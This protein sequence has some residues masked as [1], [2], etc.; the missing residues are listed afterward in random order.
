MKRYLQKADLAEV[1]VLF[2]VFLSVSLPTAFPA[3]KL[4]MLALIILAILIRGRV[5]MHSYLYAA[6]LFAGVF[7]L[8]WTIYGVEAGN[9][10]A[11]RVLTVMMVYPIVLPIIFSVIGEHSRERLVSVFLWSAIVIICFDFLVVGAS[12]FSPLQFFSDVSRTIYAEANTSDAQEYFK[13]SV[14]NIASVIFLLPFFLGAYFFGYRPIRASLLIALILSLLAIAI[15]S[16]RRA[17]LLTMFL[18]PIVAVLITRGTRDAGQSGRAGVSKL[19]SWS[20]MLISAAAVTY[21]FVDV[22]GA[23]YFANQLSSVADFAENQSNIERRLQF[24]ALY[25]GIKDSPFF[26]Q[27]AGAAASY[28]RSQEMPW[29]YELY[30]MSIAFQYGLLGFLLYSALIGV[31]L[32]WLINRVRINGRASFEF[33]YLAG[34]LAFLFASFTNPYLGKFD[35][36][37]MIFVLY[38]L[39]NDRMLKAGGVSARHAY[40]V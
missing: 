9:P 33:S 14:P 10:G 16:G 6:S 1:L 32:I 19:F 27:G 40:H 20:L 22:V 12:F 29:A 13:F 35:S 23:E 15:L 37:W 2:L 34:F 21:F 25:Q 24:N 3:A 4:S 17:L 18:G 39:M 28:S 31:Q 5:R 7:G 30:Y 11:L 8:L 38:A 36:M 26:G